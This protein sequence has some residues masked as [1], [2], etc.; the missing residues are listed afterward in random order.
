MITRTQLKKLH[1][2]KLPL[3]ILEQD[4]I[5]AL[6]LI[7]LY[8]QTESLVFKGGTLLKPQKKTTKTPSKKQPKNY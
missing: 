2:E 3:H 4:Y 5:Q 1:K 7:E 6:I 8:N